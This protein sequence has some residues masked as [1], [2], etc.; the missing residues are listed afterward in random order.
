MNKNK[1]RKCSVGRIITLNWFL[2]WLLS[3]LW[4]LCKIMKKKKK[5]E[6]T[7]NLALSYQDAWGE[8]QI[9]LLKKKLKYQLPNSIACQIT[10]VSS[11][12][13][14]KDKTKFR[15]QHY[16]VYLSISPGNNCNDNYI[17]ETPRRISEG[18]IGHNSR[19]KDSHFFKH[20]LA[21]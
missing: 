19:D 4:I 5:N 8:L 15:H 2:N 3:K 13:I 6:S 17:G 7:K 16:L 10:Y 14:I 21:K 20:F 9:K 11:H 1:S 18:I 12:F